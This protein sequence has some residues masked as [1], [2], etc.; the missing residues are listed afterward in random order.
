MDETSCT[1]P[2]SLFCRKLL[3]F[4]AKLRNQ[5]MQEGCFFSE[6]SR[7]SYLTSSAAFFLI[8][9]IKIN[10]DQN[11]ENTNAENKNCL[12]TTIWSLA[13]PV[14]PIP[15]DAALLRSTH[16]GISNLEW[17][18]IMILN[19]S[20]TFLPFLPIYFFALQCHTPFRR[21]GCP[22]V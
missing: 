7:E 18:E 19:Y 4:A 11:R 21:V 16:S 10:R 6:M 9:E 17:A 5:R 20:E 2:I 8:P 14:D 1:R 13:L 12:F 15:E 22:V 3:N